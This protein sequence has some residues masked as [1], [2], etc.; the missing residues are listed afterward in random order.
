[1]IRLKPSLTF[2]QVNVLALA[3]GVLV[4]SLNKLLWS[5]D[6]NFNFLMVVLLGFIF[7]SICFL[8]FYMHELKQNAQHELEIARRQQSE[9]EKALILS[10]LKQLQSQIEPHFLFN[11]LANLS[12]LIDKDPAMAKILLEKLT[13]LLRATLKKIAAIW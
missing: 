6:S 12:V 10:Q 7:S 8:I 2:N 5:D 9:Q 1:M 4:G 3:C 13:D 11:T